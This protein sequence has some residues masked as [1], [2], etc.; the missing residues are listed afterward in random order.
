[1][2]GILSAML[3]GVLGG[4]SAILIKHTTTEKF[5]QTHKVL[6]LLLWL[7]YIVTFPISMPIGYGYLL[8]KYLKK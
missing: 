2:T 1:M 4:L 3:M 7:A 5:R 6:E 8:F